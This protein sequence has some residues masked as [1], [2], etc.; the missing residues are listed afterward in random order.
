MIRFFALAVTLSLAGW[1][2]ASACSIEPS[3]TQWYYSLS[4]NDY[5]NWDTSTLSVGLIYSIEKKRKNRNVPRIYF[6]ESQEKKPFVKVEYELIEDISGDFSLDKK[7]WIPALSELEIDRELELKT[8][9][10]DFAYW[11]LRDLGAPFVYGYAG[12]TSCG[13]SPVPTHLPGQFYLQFKKDGK[14][15]GMEIVTGPE[16]PFVEDWRR[17]YSDAP[18]SK[19]KRTAKSYFTEISGYQEIEIE[20]CPTEEALDEISYGWAGKGVDPGLLRSVNVFRQYDAHNS[21]IENLKIIDFDAYQ[22]TLKKEKWVCEDG[23]Q[24]LVLD[25]HSEEIDRGQW[26]TG[27]RAP[28]HRYI[29]IENGNIDTN[30]ILSHITILPNENG[31]IDV[32]VVQVKNWIREANPN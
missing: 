27:D 16:D 17:I 14:T 21:E 10:R 25:K 31:S 28:K 18:T 30:D 6:D 12:D 13:L 26:L 19:I 24:Y 9:S 4:P 29:K 8:T 22:K 2:S 3:T 15:I 1:S 7:Q 23:G 5:T 11:D 20:I 32:S